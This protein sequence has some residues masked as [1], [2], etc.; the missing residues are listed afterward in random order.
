MTVRVTISLTCLTPDLLCFGLLISK[1]L[2]F[3]LTSQS[4]GE[5]ALNGERT[6]EVALRGDSLVEKAGEGGMRRRPRRAELGAEAGCLKGEGSTV[7]VGDLCVSQLHE[8][9]LCSVDAADDGMEVGEEPPDVETEAL[10]TGR[11]LAMLMLLRKSVY[12]VGGVIGVLT[13]SSSLIK[14]PNPG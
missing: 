2:P 10:S 11:G 12:A 14:S 13:P 5:R 7:E 9:S 6:A 8:Q 1:Y 4:Y 3:A